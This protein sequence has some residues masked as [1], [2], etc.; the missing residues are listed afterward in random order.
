MVT[1]GNQL[2]KVSLSLFLYGL[3][4]G[5]GPCLASCGPPLISYIAATRKGYL[6]GLGAYIL[7]SL[8]RIFVY[9]LLALVIFF[10]G[11]FALKRL[12]EGYSRYIFLAAGLFLCSIGSLVAA[13]KN[14]KVSG[15]ANALALGFIAG[16]LPCGP[17]LAI[18]SY[19]GLAAKSLPQALLYALAFAAG[20]FISPLIVLAMLAGSLQRFFSGRYAFYRRIFN[21]ICGLIIVILGFLLMRKAF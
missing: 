5:S 17:L 12:S 18:L 8:A 7:F 16:I 11:D 19:I 21:I 10:L 9:I 6:Q 20:T 4:F 1:N 13:G 14:L 2:I 3:I 15:K